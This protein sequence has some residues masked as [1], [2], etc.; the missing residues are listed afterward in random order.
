MDN[1]D[2]FGQAESPALAHVA[3]PLPAPPVPV[4]KIAAA[5][6]RAQAKI[7]APEKNKNVKVFGKKKDGTP[8]EYSFDYADYG[9]IV[10]AIRGPLSENEICFTHLVEWFGTRA[11][12]L[13]TKLIHSSG[14]ELCSIYPLPMPSEDPK[15]FGAA[16]TYGKRYSLSAITG[17][18]ADDDVDE[19]PQNT[20]SF[21]PKNSKVAPPAQGTGTSP[22]KSSPSQAAPQAKKAIAPTSSQKPQAAAP[23]SPPLE[24]PFVTK[25][26]VT[27]L[28]TIAKSGKDAWTQAQL[29]EYID[30]RWKIDSTTKLKVSQYNLICEICD[31][32]TFQQALAQAATWAGPKA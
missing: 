22:E 10:A 15:G 7:V 21:G 5:L 25:D 13:V 18:V 26:Q 4:S 30:L 19:D 6:A 9:A 24:D 2:T 23:A 3:K 31:Q 16:V 1:F 8:Y 11:V 29:K 14:E 32:M 28:Y 12:V 27:R 20:Q 17:C